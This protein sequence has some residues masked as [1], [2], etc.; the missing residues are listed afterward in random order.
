MTQSSEP[1][2]PAPPRREWG[3]NHLIW[4]LLTLSL[5]PGAIAGAAPEAWAALPR[6][7]R[8]AAYTV[9][10]VLIAVGV[11]MIVKNRD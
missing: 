9:S 2:S 11:G 4:L 6:P 8:T 3:R 7:I 1:Q 5:L 10:G